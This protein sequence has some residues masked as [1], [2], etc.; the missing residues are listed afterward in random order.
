VEEVAEDVWLILSM[1]VVSVGR[2]PGDGVSF[3]KTRLRPAPPPAPRPPVP[4]LP[5]TDEPRVALDAELDGLAV[6]VEGAARIAVRC[7]RQKVEAVETARRQLE[8]LAPTGQGVG[9]SGHGGAEPQLRTPA[10]QR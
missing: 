6:E 4:L 7:S 2:Q 3:E 5:A 10:V 1:P 8:C 9:A